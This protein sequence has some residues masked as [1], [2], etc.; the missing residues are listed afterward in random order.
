MYFITNWPTSL[1]EEQTGE[2]ALL[3]NHWDS[4]YSVA[5]EWKINATTIGPGSPL[6]VTP[7]KNDQGRHSYSFRLGKDNGS[8]G[9]N[10]GQPYFEYSAPS[11][12]P[13]TF[14][15]SSRQPS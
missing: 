11:Q 6:S 5:V 15:R 12:L 3:S 1:Q 13:M 2:F 14:C 7:S 8:G 4:T 10:A 9:V